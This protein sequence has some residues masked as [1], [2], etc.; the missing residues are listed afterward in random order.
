[1][2]HEQ[3]VVAKNF[4][5]NRDRT[6]NTIQDPASESAATFVHQQHRNPPPL[7]VVND[8]SGRNAATNTK[9]GARAVHLARARVHHAV[10]AFRVDVLAHEVL[11][12]ET[13]DATRRPR[14][15]ATDFLDP[16][17]GQ[18]DHRIAVP[19]HE[20]PAHTNGPADERANRFFRS[21]LP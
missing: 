5:R 6:P 19:I 20:R 12:A 21:E 9:R 14:H 13:F 1:M 17:V 15:L 11:L 3:I 4:P 10:V 18:L 8:E 2:Q 16:R 7:P